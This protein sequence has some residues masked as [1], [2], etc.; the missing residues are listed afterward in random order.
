MDATDERSLVLTPKFFTLFFEKKRV[1]RCLFQI[2]QDNF[3][4][5][6]LDYSAEVKELLGS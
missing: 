6:V 4:T 5:E 2:Y 3:V 1:G